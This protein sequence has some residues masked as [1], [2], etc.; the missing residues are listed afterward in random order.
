MFI[1]LFTID[2][3]PPPPPYPGTS[4]SSEATTSK[5]ALAQTAGKVSLI[6]VGINQSNA[7]SSA[8]VT[9]SSLLSSRKMVINNNTSIDNSKDNVRKLSISGSSD[10]D[11][12]NGVASTF[13]TSDGSKSIIINTSDAVMHTNNNK[14]AIGSNISGVKYLLPISP[15]QLSSGKLEKTAWSQNGNLQYEKT[16]FQLF[17]NDISEKIFS[18]IREKY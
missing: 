3:L 2:K 6:N 11:L 7:S 10:E 12:L 5:L 16:G 8:A 18:Q 4:G 9:T 1:Y 13:Q 17:S 15:I 14:I